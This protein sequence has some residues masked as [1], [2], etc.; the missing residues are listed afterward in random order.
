MRGSWVEVG[1]GRSGDEVVP[2]GGEVVHERRSDELG[3]EH[4]AGHGLGSGC[5]GG[6]ARARSAKSWCR[7]APMPMPTTSAPWAR[8]QAASAAES[9]WPVTLS[10]VSP[11]GRPMKTS[12]RRPSSPS[13]GRAANTSRSDISTKS[14]TPPVRI[15]RATSRP[16]ASGLPCASGLSRIPT[17]KRSPVA[18]RIPVEHLDQGP[19]PV[20]QGCRRSRLGVGCAGRGTGPGGNRAPRA[21]RPRRSRPARPAPQRPQSP[22]PAAARRRRSSRSAQSR[23]RRTGR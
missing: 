4:V 3:T 16:S 21:P 23:R 19:H 2:V 11:R 13:V 14:T 15:C 12:M 6:S 7:I 17:W 22:R 10:T 1:A 18:A 8:H 20:L 9:T 5:E